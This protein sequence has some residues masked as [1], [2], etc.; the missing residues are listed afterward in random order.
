MG[1]SVLHC[2]WE[3]MILISSLFFLFVT[4]L[5]YKVCDNSNAMTQCNFQKNYGI[6][7]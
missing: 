2:L 4:L 5:N 7:A 1:L 6:T 3:V